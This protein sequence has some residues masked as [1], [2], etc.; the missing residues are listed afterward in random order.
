MRRFRWR[1]I[2]LSSAFGI[3]LSGASRAMAD[4]GRV[5]FSQ[6]VAPYRITVFT[7]PTPLRA[8]TVDISVLVQQAETGDVVHDTTIDLELHSAEMTIRQRATA[9]MSTNKLLQSATFVLPSTGLWNVSIGVRKTSTVSVEFDMTAYESSRIG[10]TLVSCLMIPFIVIA[11]FLLR[12]YLMAC[13]R[14]GKEW[15]GG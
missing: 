15:A 3:L 11:L 9:E 10:P 14:S 4:G 7:S 13:Q 2:V 8:G 1:S 5:Q 12:E 6:I